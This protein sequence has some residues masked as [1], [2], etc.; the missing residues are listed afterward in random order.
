MNYH[1]KKKKTTAAVLYPIDERAQ[2][3]VLPIIIMMMMEMMMVMRVR[4]VMMM[5][6]MT[7]LN[8][9]AMRKVRTI[10]PRPPRN[11][12]FGI[13]LKIVLKV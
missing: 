8:N 2:S 5:M 1:L 7:S 4:M 9:G 11:V 3:E 6:M 13:K 10:Q 12:K